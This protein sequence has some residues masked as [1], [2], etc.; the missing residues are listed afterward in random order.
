MEILKVKNVIK[1]FR[2]II[3]VNNVS[4]SVEAG[5][6]FGLLGPNGAGKT[7]MLRMITNIYMPDSG[8]ITFFDQPV[9]SQ[10]QNRIGYLPEERGLYKKLKVIEQLTYF[11]MLKDM[12]RQNAKAEALKWLAEFGAAD[13]AGKKIQ[14][15][16]KG[17][18]QKV[19]FITTILHKPDFL[20][21][22]EPF[23]GFDPINVE[24]IKK[25]ILRMKD[26]G[27]T[28]ILS[29]HVMQQVEE[30]CDDICLI[31]KGKVI[32]SG[33]VREIKKSFGRDTVI[34]EFEGNNDFLDSFPGIEYINKSANRA[35]FKLNGINSSDVLKAASENVK[36]FRF[37]LVEPNFHE[38]FI[39]VVN[40]QEAENE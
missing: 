38:I 20:I 2:D 17:M 21:L 36:V 11:G 28:I 35:E 24:A 23:T 39:D 4:F 33:K 31:N 13:W 40:K 7:T 1:T 34:M 15:L 5:K 29:T 26:D 10:L 25:I 8:S 19:Q 27:K 6:I 30:L 37:E 9:N 22:D 12:S 18:Q 32:L 3:A 16:S 14:E